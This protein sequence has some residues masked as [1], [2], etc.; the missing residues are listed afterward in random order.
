MFY[1][2]NEIVRSARAYEMKVN[3]GGAG[4]IAIL[5]TGVYGHNDLYGRIIDYKDIIANRVSLYDDNGHGTHI[6]GI[7]AGNGKSSKGKIMGVSARCP[8]VVVKVLERDGN[9]KVDNVLKGCD[10]VIKN[11]DKLNIRLVNISMG[12]EV[13]NGDEEMERLLEGVERMWECGMVVMVAGGNNGPGPM[14]ITAPGNSKKVITVG[15][16]DDDIRSV[17]KNKNYSGRGPTVDCVVKPDIVTVG[18]NIMSLSNMA[19]GYMKRSGTSMATAVATAVVGVFMEKH[20]SFT[21]KDIKKLLI[22][23][24]VD[25]G[26]SSQIQGNGMLNIERLFDL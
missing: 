13:V 1:S 3:S 15:A 26:K 19:N 24:A 9:G 14:S 4:A 10:Y 11:K 25:M 17:V 22:N 23:S 7:I 20:W 8:L 5:D 16:C 18:S 12:A 21:P 2:Y 6:C